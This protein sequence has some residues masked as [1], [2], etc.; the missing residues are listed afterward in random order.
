MTSSRTARALVLAIVPILIAVLSIDT[1]SGSVEVSIGSKVEARKAFNR[2][3]RAA[4]RVVR[5]MRRAGRAVV[6]GVGSA[7]KK[8][9]SKFGKAGKAIGGAVGK[10]AKG[11]GKAAEK[12][13]KGVQTIG[14]GVAQGAKDLS[15]GKVGKA[16]KGVAKTAVKGA[17]QIG[18]GVIAAV[19]AIGQVGFEMFAKF[20]KPAVQML[21]KKGCGGIIDLIVKKTPLQSLVKKL[22]PMTPVAGCATEFVKG[23]I[24]SIPD[25]VLDAANLVMDVAK[26]AWKHKNVCLPAALAGMA[27]A[28]A[29]LVPAAACGLGFYVADKVKGAI[30]CFGKMKSTLGSHWQELAK[31]LVMQGCNMAGGFAFDIASG[32]ILSVATAGAG[33][34]AV[35]AKAAMKVLKVINMVDKMTSAIGKLNGM[36]SCS[37]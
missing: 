22:G 16:I 10:A 18:K 26:A 5:G 15:K 3:K 23:F 34:V 9:G 6:K 29:P 1:G 37:K 8:I 24:C 30:S 27:I 32:I 17:K 35:V 36:G 28:A 4:R 20:V 14:K 12:V 25:V 7:A 21:L 19:T 2:V 11:V 33:L 13:G 31:T